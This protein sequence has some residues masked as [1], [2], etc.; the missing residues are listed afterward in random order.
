[1]ALKK[2]VKNKS[3]ENNTPSFLRGFR[4]YIIILI[5]I[6]II[7]SHTLNFK[8]TYLDD[9]RLILDN[10]HFISKISNIVEAFK[11]DVF[12]DTTNNA[13]YRPIM[14]ISL[15][16][17]AYLG[18]TSPLFYHLTNIIIHYLCSCLVFIFLLKLGYQRFPSFISS[19]FFTVHPALCQAVS[20][21]GGRND[22][23][24]ALFILLSLITLISYLNTRKTTKLLIHLLTFT[25]AIFTKETALVFPF[26]YIFISRIM[27]KKIFERQ[28]ISIFTSYLIIILLWYFMRKNALSNP[29]NYTLKDII[30]SIINN[31][32]AI[33]LYI[34]KTL[35]PFNLSVLP[36][37]SDNTLIWGYI[38]VVILIFLVYFSKNKNNL[39]MIFGIFWFIIFLLPAF[40]RP[41]LNLPA[42][43]IEHR[44]YLPMI[45]FI[46]FLLE[47]GNIKN[48]EFKINFLNIAILA[49]L[50]L[51]SI[52]NISYSY[53]F[54]DE[55][56]FWENA[57]IHS[58]SYPLA[59]R[60]L[61]AMYYLRGEIDKAEKEYLECLKLNPTEPMVHNN[62]GL[63]YMNRGEFKK[64][65][66]EF[67]TE[68]KYYP[69]YDTAYYNLGLLYLR[70]SKINEAV[71]LF[72]KTIEINPYYFDAY[73]KLSLIFYILKDFKQS[74]FYIDE[75]LK[76][77]GKIN[78]E[79][80]KMVEQS[81]HHIERK[82]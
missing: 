48:I 72:K 33:L 40:I 27:N 11:H 67:L 25:L 74:K 17:D 52:I 82:K 18:G 39:Y 28:N 30:N 13:Y 60:N 49:I 7:Y 56:S 22:T 54:K 4:P 10:F 44:I 47:A 41:N 20:W 68:L 57:R 70:Q 77:N 53:N 34:G 76:R 71:N 26:L 42:D 50:F 23:L 38:V 2:S 6:A 21:I 46:I 78:P 32:P 14:T 37:L 16:I 58:P 51:F 79:I 24:L 64:A 9:N 55:L 65:E 12:I 66:E 62:L 35:L 8:F 15:I 31:F 29:L 5:I 80:I 1:M 73:E 36:I 75:A 19:L 3:E 61:G 43:F 59:R 63:I 69:N 81:I 45:G